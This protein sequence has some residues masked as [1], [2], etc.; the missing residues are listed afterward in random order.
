MPAPNTKTVRVFVWREQF[1]T[2]NV[3][4]PEH[5]SD[6]EVI[7]SLRGNLRAVS[8]MTQH[9][10]SDDWESEIPYPTGVEPVSGSHCFHHEIIDTRQLE[11]V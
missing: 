4:V 7:E 5:Y 1:A 11:A 9:L 8:A 2:V 6:N 3:R 10:E